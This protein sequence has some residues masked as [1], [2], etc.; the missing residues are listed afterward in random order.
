MTEVTEIQSD[1]RCQTVWN[2][3]MLCV[4]IA[5][6]LRVKGLVGACAYVSLYVYLHAFSL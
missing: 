5:E 6:E 3:C 4:K 1:I 2:Q